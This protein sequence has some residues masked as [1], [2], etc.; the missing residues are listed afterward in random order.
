MH[1]QHV[2]QVMFSDY[3]SLH[4]ITFCITDINELCDLVIHA[5]VLCSDE[6]KLSIYL[7]YVHRMMRIIL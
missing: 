1:S 5:I 4:D 2:T 6:I 7:I 3:I